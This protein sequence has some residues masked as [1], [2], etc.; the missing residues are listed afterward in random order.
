M[1]SFRPLIGVIISNLTYQKVYAIV[2]SCF[3]PLIGVIISNLI[4]HAPRHENFIVSVPLSGL[5]FLIVHY[6]KLTEGP[7]GKVSVPLSGLSF[8][9]THITAAPT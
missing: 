3:R 2:N 5:S 7:G 9:I 4:I 6:A 1:K 8:L